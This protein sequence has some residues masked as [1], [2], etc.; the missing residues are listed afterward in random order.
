MQVITQDNLHLIL[1][2]KIGIICTLIS[3]NSDM[4]LLEA[5]QYFY[6]SQV[7]HLLENE[8]TK[9][10]YESGEQI[11]ANYFQEFQ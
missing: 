6:R 4:N 7:Y 1:P 10:W 2:R 3:E 5:T 9:L 11:F 8:K